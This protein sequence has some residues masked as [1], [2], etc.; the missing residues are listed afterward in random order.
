M[1]SPLGLTLANVFL[2]YHEKIW[3]QNCPS[4]F[5][6]VI[7]RRYV[8][9]TF[10][11]FR[12][13][14]HIEK[15]RN[16]LNRQHKNTKFTSEIENENPISFLDIKITRDKKKFI[17]SVYRKTTFN[18]VFTN[19]GS[20]FPKS[21]KYN[22]LFT[23]LHR[24]FRLCSNFEHFHQEIEKLKTISENNGYPKSFVDFCIKKY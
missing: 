16:Y 5:K 14:D 10:Q 3:P 21:Y 12:S 13:K 20:F 2:C 17:T 8:D 7:Y 23:L 1:G 22:L 15:F 9:D 4:E 24:V 19:F 18:G 6:T 11:L